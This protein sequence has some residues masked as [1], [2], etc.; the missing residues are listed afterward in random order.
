M[1]HASW[2]QALRLAYTDVPTLLKALGL[3]V[4][5]IDV[6]LDPSF[7]IRVPEAF[8]LRMQVSNPH[9]P[10]LRQVL[11]LKIE[12]DL[13]PGFQQDPL[14]EQTYNAVPGILH[15]YQG[16]ALLMPTSA[17]AV[18]CR[19]CFRRHFPYADNRL[20]RPKLSAALQY[21]QNDNSIHEVILSGGDPLLLNDQALDVL[22][23]QLEQ[24]PHLVRLR[25]H[26]RTPIVLPQ[27][28]TPVFV[29][30]LK[31]SRFQ[32]VMVLH[33]NHPNEIDASIEAM[34]KQLNEAGIRVLNQTVLL[35]CV[36]DDPQVLIALSERLF[37]AGIL[38]YYLH[39]LDPVQGAAHFD[40]ED[41]RALEL[42]QV[43]QAKLSG[44][45]VPKLVR[46]VPGAVAKQNVESIQPE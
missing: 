27:R 17:C 16:R 4:E 32:A 46:E 23:T 13:V 31:A 20:D 6:D 40:V 5:E 3:S 43:M 39:Q 37:Q 24:I 33:C 10:L 15:K 38:P 29:K 42:H 21:L 12:R 45:L 35:R 30:R 7:P 28:I 41:A 44:Y 9:D 34:G 11:P 22:I 8:V 19:Y 25:I 36:N 1:E 26:T 2:Q 18:N 14:S